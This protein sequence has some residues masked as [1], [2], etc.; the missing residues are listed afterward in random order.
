[1]SFNFPLKFLHFYFQ[2]EIY[3]IFKYFFFYFK[4]VTTN[5]QIERGILE[6]ISI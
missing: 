5:C 6:K 3:T 2:Q 1:M 4:N